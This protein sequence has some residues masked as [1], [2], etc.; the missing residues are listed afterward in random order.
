MVRERRYE[1]KGKM[2]KEE[3]MT[4]A[5]T[6]TVQKALHLRPLWRPRPIRSPKATKLKAVL[7]PCS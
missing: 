5:A 6:E 7:S 2:G 3:E 1:K 4:M